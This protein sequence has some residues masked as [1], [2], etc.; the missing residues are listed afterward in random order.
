M[1]HPNASTRE[2]LEQRIEALAPGIEIYKPEGRGPFPVV[3]QLHG[4]GGKKAL[5]ARWAAAAREAGWA[6]IVV[7]S[8]RHRKISSL[9]AYT[10]VCMGL[11]LWGKERAG[12]AYAAMEWARRQSWADPKM[13]V[14]AGWSHGGWTALDAMAMQPGKEMEDATGLTGFT[15]EP[16]AGLSGAFLVYPFA[17][18][19]S[20]ARMKGLR[21]DVSPVAIVGTH[22]MIV[23]GRSLARTLENM[24]TPGEPIEVHLFEGATHAFDEIEARDFRVTY[25]PDVTAH[26]QDIYKEYLTAIRSGAA[27]IRAAG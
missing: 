7:D 24:P 11:R 19:G 5:Q 8:Y 17:G 14:L 16:L 3:I 4:C 22:D 1:L 25:D 18:P 2:T 9:E 13:L 20:I 10:T 27:N 6:A 23:G 26:S 21:V 15:K 12:D